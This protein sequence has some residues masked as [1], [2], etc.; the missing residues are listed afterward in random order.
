MTT[1]RHRIHRP[2]AH[3]PI[4]PRWLA[5]P[6]LVVAALAGALS[7]K[8]IGSTPMLRQAAAPSPAGAPPAPPALADARAVAEPLP[9]HYPLVTPTGTI[10]VAALARHGRLRGTSD[11]W[12]DGADRA[13][14]EAEADWALS[15]AEIERLAQWQ[16]PRSAPRTSAPQPVAAPARPATD[17]TPGASSKPSGA[18]AVSAPAKA[19]AR[20]ATT[21]PAKA[22]SGTLAIAAKP[23]AAPAAAPPASTAPAAPAPA[24]GL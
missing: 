12:S 16:P 8:S 7:G 1:P 11:A 18:L 21:V 3:R 19:P 17:A 14:L 9:D 15:E 5:A 23:A 4:D 13:Y 2:S 22:R 24:P 10:P 20:A 6:L